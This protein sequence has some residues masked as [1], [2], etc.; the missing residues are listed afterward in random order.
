MKPLA[1]ATSHTLA[2]SLVSTRTG[3][4]AEVEHEARL[5]GRRDDEIEQRH[6]ALGPG[7]VAVEAADH[8]GDVGAAAL[9]QAQV[10]E[11]WRGDGIDGGVK[12][13]LDERARAGG[14]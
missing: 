10:G 5:L 1:R 8:V 13:R 7:G 4:R 3:T 12:R 6:L 14:R 2:S 11:R 9:P